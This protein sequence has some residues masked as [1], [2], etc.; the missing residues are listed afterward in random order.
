MKLDRAE[1]KDEFEHYVAELKAMEI[2]VDKMRF[3]LEVYQRADVDAAR[4][5][6]STASM[7]LE[8]ARS[9]LVYG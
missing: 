8:E 6:L 9:W 7:A 4:S 5:L 3:R 2:L 1:L